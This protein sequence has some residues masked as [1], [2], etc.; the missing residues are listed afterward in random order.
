MRRKTLANMGSPGGLTTPGNAVAPGNA[1][2][3]TVVLDWEVVLG[4]DGVVEVVMAAAVLEGIGD[5]Y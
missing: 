3:E 5:V 2:M 1:G 4:V